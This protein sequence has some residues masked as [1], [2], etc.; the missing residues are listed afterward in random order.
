[1]EDDHTDP[2]AG[3]AG[4]MALQAPVDRLTHTVLRAAVLELREAE[5]RVRFPAR[6]H[7]GIPG[8]SRVHVL[9]GG[10]DDAGHRA[11][12]A[13]ALLHAAGRDVPR[14]YAW[15]SRPGEGTVEDADLEWSSAVRWAADAL[16]TT[17]GLVVVTRSGWFD[18]VSGVCR[19]WRRLRRHPPACRS[20]TA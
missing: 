10:P 2:S 17:T 20:G 3:Q 18:P 6:V 13:L 14:P 15:L 5:P 19:E 1:V 9:G 7:A 11:E 12:L 8:R 4:A 16:G